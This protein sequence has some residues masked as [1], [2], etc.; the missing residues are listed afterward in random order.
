[1]SKLP[2]R[3]AVLFVFAGCATL[4]QPTPVEA[5]T[6]C[7]TKRPT[8]RDEQELRAVVRKVAGSKT[9]RLMIQDFCG[10]GDTATADLQS[11]LA[12]QR[13]DIR[14]WSTM[15]CSR[16]D[17]LGWACEKLV[18]HRATKLRAILAGTQRVIE[19][20]FPPTMPVATARDLALRALSLIEDPAAQ[21][22]RCENSQERP[23]SFL[24]GHWSEARDAVLKSVSDLPF[25]VEVWT[26]DDNS[27]SATPQ[28]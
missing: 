26:Q 10:R 24:H 9:S 25:P 2:F 27:R 16:E 8:A 23:V 13:H 22:A 1:M 20:E 11:P 3:L 6:P 15:H 4:A 12:R 21:P 18:S 5:S 28:V 17:V 7:S 14:E 19:V